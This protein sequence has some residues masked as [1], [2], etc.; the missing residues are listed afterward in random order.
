MLKLSNANAGY[1]RLDSSKRLKGCLKA[2]Y[3]WKNG[4]KQPRGFWMKN[5]QKTLLLRAPL[6]AIGA[7]K[8]QDFKNP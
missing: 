5:K 6:V 8:K 4:N 1:R 7:E 3:S 2:L